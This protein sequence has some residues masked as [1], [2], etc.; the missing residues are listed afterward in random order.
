MPVLLQDA[1]RHHVSV[2]RSHRARTVLGEPAPL[3][4]C[5]GG[6]ARRFSVGGRDVS[7]WGGDGGHGADRVAF[8][9]LNGYRRLLKST[10]LTDK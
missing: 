6:S 5:G 9:G 8:N 10:E 7:G 4:S 2:L 1:A 3:Y